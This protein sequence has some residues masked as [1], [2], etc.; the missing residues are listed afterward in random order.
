[1]TGDIEARFAA[2]LARAEPLVAA[3]MA[4]A[5]TKA[6]K[7]PTVTRGLWQSIVASPRL[8]EW[9][10]E[11]REWIWRRCTLPATSPT[12]YEREM[13]SRARLGLPPIP[14]AGA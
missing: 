5:P 3:D 12:G 1:V 2:A 9:P 13:F 11:V 10:P 6:A 14:K 4:L 7:V 8:L